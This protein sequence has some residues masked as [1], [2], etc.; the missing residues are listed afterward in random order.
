MA[1]KLKVLSLFKNDSWQN[2]FPAI[3]SLKE[4]NYFLQFNA[5]EVWLP[6]PSSEQSDLNIFEI[7]VLRLISAGIISTD[8]ISEKICLQKDLINFIFA[9]LA[10]SN[11]I[12]STKKITDKGLAALGK[13]I[14]AVSTDTKPCLI[15]TTCDT[16]EILPIF[17]PLA[18]RTTGD[19]EKPFLTVNFGT[20]G[21]AKPVKGRCIFVKSSAPKAQILP[22]K[23]LHNAIK[24][25]NRSTETKIFLDSASN[26]VS[27]YSEKIFLHI[28]TVLQDGNIDYM[29][30][31]EGLK[32][33]NDFLREYLDRQPINFLQYLKESAGRL[34]SKKVT[35]KNKLQGQYPEI[36]ALLKRKETTAES[37]DERLDEKNLQNWQ[38]ENL[39]KAVEWALF[40]HLKKFPPPETVLEVM[41]R[42]M[43]E[44]NFKNVVNFA[45][46]LGLGKIE[47]YPQLFLNL[48]AMSVKNCITSK[49]P[50]I[51]ILLGLNIVAAAKNPESHL[52]EALNILPGDGFNFLNRLDNYGKSLRHGETWTAKGNDTSDSLYKNVLL[53][54]KKLLPDYENIETEKEDLSNASMKKLNAQLAVMKAIGEEI[55]Q[56]FPYSLQNY[57]LKISPDKQGTQMLGSLEFVKTLSI[58][59]EK[60]ISQKILDF[61]GKIT[62]PKSEIVLRLK[63]LNVKQNFQTVS[64][65]FYKNACEK[66]ISTLGGYTLAYSATL[67]DEDLKKLAEKNFF[68]TVF[69]IAGL[70]GHVNNILFAAEEENLI[71]LRDKVFNIVKF[72]EVD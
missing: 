69:E 44:E 23:K 49:N 12:D 68:E 63:N 61:A 48:S 20:T 18:E 57:F 41:S 64:D 17:F 9:R 26:I 33:H 36:R 8:E 39:S 52:I 34:S 60:I 54:V 21:K 7:T 27:T 24:I 11:F 45:K 25:F 50:D 58:I 70:R 46:Q 43:Q 30:V 67:N 31:S 72:L 32:M 29:I 4:E 35:E 62:S 37:V 47:Y 19:F 59:L 3:K 16:G 53:F 42:Q 2:K 66:K 5:Y 22:Q 38:V 6:L 71:N 40:Y 28:K 1:K 14:N 15:L 13:N 65:T 55:F 56:R 51:K 10:E